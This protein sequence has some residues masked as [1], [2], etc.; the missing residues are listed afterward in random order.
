[1]QTREERT[2]LVY[3]VEIQVRD[4]AGAL[5]IGMP[6]EVVFAAPAASSRTSATSTL[7]EPHRPLSRGDAGEQSAKADF[8]PSLQ[9]IHPPR[10]ASPERLTLAARGG[11]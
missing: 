4:P 3:A 9:R 1:V 7:G 5:K 6:G 10:S 2:G 8:G 11:R